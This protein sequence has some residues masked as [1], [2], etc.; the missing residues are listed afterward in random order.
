MVRAGWTAPTYSFADLGLVQGTK[1]VAES[2]K[3]AFAQS[4]PGSACGRRA[5]A[6]EFSGCK[7]K[8]TAKRLAP[9][10]FAAPPPKRQSQ[11]K[12][13]SILDKPK[14]VRSLQE[15]FGVDARVST[16]EAEYIEVLKEG[17]SGWAV[18]TRCNTLC[19]HVTRALESPL[20]RRVCGR[21]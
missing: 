21:I 2:K 14:S 16:T 8:Q 6:L 5:S 13:A 15:E 20:R 7:A 18:M 11:A 19:A 1:D 3:E 10:E 4:T 12:S 9:S 17:S